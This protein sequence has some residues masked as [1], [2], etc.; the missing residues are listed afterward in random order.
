M[1][2][3]SELVRKRMTKYDGIRVGTANVDYL[4]EATPICVIVLGVRGPCR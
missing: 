1:A 2:E 3:E 4:I